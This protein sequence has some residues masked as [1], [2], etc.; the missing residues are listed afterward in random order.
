MK[1]TLRWLL[2]VHYVMLLVGRVILVSCVFEI[3]VY[4]FSF[5]LRG[6]VSDSSSILQRPIP[7]G[8]LCWVVWTTR[9]CSVDV[10]YGI[11]LPLCVNEVDLALKL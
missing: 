1:K 6:R 7:L 2:F 10:L 8:T 9:K 5:H 11:H 3:C 4:L